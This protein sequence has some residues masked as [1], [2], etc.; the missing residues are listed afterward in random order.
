MIRFRLQTTH[1]QHNLVAL[2]QSGFRQRSTLH[3]HGQRG[4]TSHSCNAAL[5]QEANFR[6]AFALATQGNAQYI[7]AGRV[8]ALHRNVGSRDFPNIPRIL[9]MI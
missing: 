8:L 2:Q 6:N 3:Q 9:K 7:A 5:S 1:G 4:R